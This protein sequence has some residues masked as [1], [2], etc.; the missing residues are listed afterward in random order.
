M[1]LPIVATL[2]TAAIRR[3]ITGCLTFSHTR[4]CLL[5]PRFVPVTLT[6]DQ[7]QQFIFFIIPGLVAVVV[8]S[9]Y[10]VN[11]SVLPVRTLPTWP[12]N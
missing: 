10:S 3:A 2:L 9:V 6:P 1:H 4:R 5:L 11:P 8:I 7:C 12:A